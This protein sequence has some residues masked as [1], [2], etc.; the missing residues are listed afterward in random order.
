MFGLAG[1]GGQ[2]I[3]VS[4]LGPS[5]AEGSPTVHSIPD[6]TSTSFMNFGGDAGDPRGERG[7]DGTGG[8]R[9][10][11]FYFVTLARRCRWWRTALEEDGDLIRRRWVCHTDWILGKVAFK[12]TDC[13]LPSRSSL[14]RIVSSN[15]TKIP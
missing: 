12:P 1:L 13:S 11:T 14:L 8:G 2:S 5:P 15:E 4:Q 7:D 6:N 3:P 9:D 10:K